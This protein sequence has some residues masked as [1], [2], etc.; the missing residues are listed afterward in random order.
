MLITVKNPIRDNWQTQILSPRL[1]QKK[2]G[3]VEPKQNYENI[4]ES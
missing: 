4:N 1:T 2:S 3:E